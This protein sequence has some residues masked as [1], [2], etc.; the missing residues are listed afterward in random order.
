[1]A[2]PTT[3]PIATASG[4]IGFS[5]DVGGRA[6]P[7]ATREP[8]PTPVVRSSRSRARPLAIAAAVTGSA[9]R[10]VIETSVLPCSTRA[11]AAARTDAASSGMPR[12]SVTRATA[13]GVTAIVANDGA[14]AGR[15]RRAS[16]SSPPGVE[17]IATM[18]TAV[19]AY[20]GAR[21]ALQASPTAAP[22]SNP[23]TRTP[24][25]RS[26]DGPS[27]RTKDG[28][29]VA[30]GPESTM[31][32]SRSPVCA[33]DVAQSCGARWNRGAGPRAGLGIP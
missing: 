6:G 13:S 12:A 25:A 8:V 20:D 7:R 29:S 23:T 11:F 16:S 30:M 33:L 31:G 1:M 21:V 3:A 26:V 5:A 9:C 2:S 17:G 22:I 28:I 14:M 19:E 10:A 24:N 15:P 4:T 27:T 18:S 32:P